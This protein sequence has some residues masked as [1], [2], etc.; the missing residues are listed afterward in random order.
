MPNLQGRPPLPVKQIF[1]WADA[2]SERQGTWPQIRPGPVE[3]VPGQMWAVCRR[4]SGAD[5]VAA[6]AV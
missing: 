4:L 3:G 1:T 6:P 2:Y 5:G